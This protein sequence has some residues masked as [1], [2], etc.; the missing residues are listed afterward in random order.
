MPNRKSQRSRKRMP[1]KCPSISSNQGS[2][3]SEERH[4]KPSQDELEVGGVLSTADRESPVDCTDAASIDGASDPRCFNS[5]QVHMEELGT[6]T[7]WSCDRMSSRKQYCLENKVQEASRKGCRTMSAV[8][9]NSANL[10]N[11]MEDNLYI[12]EAIL[13]NNTTAIL[14]VGRCSAGKALMEE[15]AQACVDHFSLC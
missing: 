7:P 9:W 14:Y 6:T 15:E 12:M 10:V 13:L 2:E 3:Q 4:S 8:L 1:K 5:S 11:L